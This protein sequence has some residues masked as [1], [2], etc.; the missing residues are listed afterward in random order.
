[1][2]CKDLEELLS[3]Y[4]DSELMGTQ[5][6]F[7]EEHLASCADCQ[8]TLADYRKIREQ[9]LSLRATPTIPDIKEATISKIKMA[10]A[11]AKLRRWLRPALVAAPIMVILMTLLSFYLSGS[12]LSTAGV[13]A[14]AYAATEKLT[15]YRTVDDEYIKRQEAGELVYCWHSEFE[16]AGPDRYHLIKE[17]TEE[18]SYYEY[19]HET[20]VIG[21]QEYSQGDF[22][23]PLKP[24]AVAE[25]TPTKDKTLEALDLLIDIETMPDETLDGV[26]CYHYRG[27]VDIEKWLDWGRPAREQ[28]F[29]NMIER[30]PT[31]D[32]DLEEMVKTA[33]NVWRT[34]EITYE[35]WIGKD[36]Y[37]IRQWKHIIQTLPDQPVL[38]VLYEAIAIIKF[39]GFNEPIVI[40][41]PL[42]ESGEL[43]PGWSVRS[44][45]E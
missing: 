2:N 38:G 4:A 11:P 44:L 3:A 41:P 30:Y 35:F 6:D 10:R 12:F 15:S 34:K 45:E 20:I 16:Y 13:I 23:Y 22:S 27:K 8:A 32:F 28:M 33:E 40:E 37:L 29:K 14:K 36:D 18:S 5:R 24:E 19:F 39:H 9:L 7:V 17:Q 26:D 31:F 43:L 42:T 25:C 21:D 1:M